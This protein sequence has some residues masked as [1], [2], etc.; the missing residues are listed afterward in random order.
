[1]K[2]HDEQLA[3]AVLRV[4]TELCEFR[5]HQENEFEWFK[6]HHRLATK[7]DLKELE[8]HI[9][10]AISTFAANQKA[11]NDRQSAAIDAAVASIT[12]LTE[13]VASLNVKILELQN[14]QGGVTPE[15]QVLIDDLQAQGEAVAARAEAL[16]AALATL[17]SQTPPVVPPP[18]A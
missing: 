6:S 4:A 5:K 16:A 1:M 15:D 9:M 11:F 2:D 10:S 7:E 14:S 17:D 13:D 8:K 12:G 18:P 3:M